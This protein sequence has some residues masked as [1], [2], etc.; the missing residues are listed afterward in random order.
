MKVEDIECVQC[1]S[2]NIRRARLRTLSDRLRILTG[3]YP[4]RCR[5]CQTRFL[6]GVLR[7]SKAPYAK[8]PRCL[9]TELGTWPQRHYNPGF[10]ANLLL[11]LGARKYRCPACRYNFVSFRR[12][13]GSRQVET[14]LESGE[15]GRD[16]A[17]FTR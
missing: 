5:E 15:A 7:L 6:A 2:H 4:F 10:A 9:R 13:L 14:V 11:E 12:R 1:G 3:V 8:C 16:V 17:L